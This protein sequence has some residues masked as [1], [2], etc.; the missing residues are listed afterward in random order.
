MSEQTQTEQTTP[1]TPSDPMVAMVQKTVSGQ[2]EQA[3]ALVQ[4]INANT[5]D[6]GKLVHD[7]RTD[8]SVSDETV[9]KF[10][11]WFAKAEAEIERRVSEV[12][13]Y[14]TA[15]LLP[16]SED[17][18]V[19]ALKAQHKS[20]KDSIK[21]ALTFV[22]TVPGYNAEEFSVPDLANLRGGTSAGT[23]TGGKRPRLNRIWVNG[24]LISKAVKD[25][26]GNDVDVSNF[27]L[28]AAAIGKLA[29]A[30]VE[31]KDLQQAAFGA[32]GTDD[33]STLNGR[34]FE[35][36]FEAG[37]G[38]NRVNVNVKVEPKNTSGETETEAATTPA[39]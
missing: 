8:E 36:A 15:N 33:L 38:E 28:A 23:G 5:T 31:V 39:E 10:Q 6:K 35:Y 9:R 13:S 12:D 22:Q 17:V 30:K 1:V 11:E 27:T 16:A 20:L 24:D 3:N 34:V 14:I 32:A 21:A 29:K 25:K 26:D 19:D 2:I 18:D 37:E 4:K 7:I